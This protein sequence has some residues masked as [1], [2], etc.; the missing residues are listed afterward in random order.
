MQASQYTQLIIQP[1]LKTNPH[2]PDHRD[3]LVCNHPYYVQSH[4][5]PY[6]T[7]HYVQRKGS[8]CIAYHSNYGIRKT[9][10]QTVS[11]L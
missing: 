5:R 6:S 11:V 2:L 7:E 8:A 4:N 10:F 3:R 9:R 1:I